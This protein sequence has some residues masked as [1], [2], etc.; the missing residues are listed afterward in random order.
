MT[1]SRRHSGHS[2]VRNAVFG[3]STWILPLGLSFIATPVIVSSLGHED[4]GIY[5]LI[6][7]FIAYSFNFNVGRAVTK[8]VAEYRATGETE[9][10]SEI[11]SATATVS[12]GVGIAGLFTIFL[13][14]GVLVDD[15]LRIPEAAHNKSVT[16][17][18][19]AA[20]TI[21]AVMINQIFSA[22]LQGVQR[23]DIYA[24]ILNTTNLLVIG[25]NLFLAWRGYDLNG[26]LL[27]NLAVTLAGAVASAVI[28]FRTIPEVR[29][30]LSFNRQSLRTV[31][32]YSR[33][34]IL[35]QILANAL[36]LFER[37]WITAKLG[38]ESLT[39]YVVPMTLG[40]SIQAFMS[41]LTLVLFPLAAELMNRPDDLRRLYQKSTKTVTFLTVFI[42]IS[43]IV[44]S[45][46]FLTAWMGGDFALASGD[47]LVA[48]VLTFGLLA[49][50]VVG[51]NMTEGLGFPKY[52]FLV[53]IL[54]FAVSVAGMIAATPAF[55]V[56]GIAIAR[57][58]GFSVLFL[59]IFLMEWR[60]FSA[61]QV[62]FWLNV[63]LR[64]AI[65]GGLA[66]VTEYFV[67]KSMPSG[68][69]GIFVATFSGGVVYCVAAVAVGLLTSEDRAILRRLAGR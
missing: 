14:T 45:D 25:G 8:Y 43:L 52:N 4:Y 54:C 6:L 31:I 5:A 63:G 60:F 37:A 3:V 7:G 62:S 53:F 68:W 55:G 46:R 49:I 20:G 18:Y 15:V 69:T 57:L 58:I 11:V 38:P 16:A 33:W 21:L 66:G 41:S 61:V 35:Y 56:R 24:K 17:L 27:W 32:D 42:V 19:L 2:V 23:F 39:Y 28:V 51:W 64:T 44:Q 1:E 67:G 47:L 48:H 10:I 12:I 40:L 26:L 9:K 65:A 22:A 13:F 36:L 29:F 59:G 30:R 50:A 34:V